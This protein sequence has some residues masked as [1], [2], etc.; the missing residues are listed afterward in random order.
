MPL[1]LYPPRPG[2]TPN[3]TIRGTYLGLR[4][5]K[6]AG[7]SRKATAQRELRRIEQ[8]IEAGRFDA[9]P[10]QTFADAVCSYL[11]GGGD[12]RFIEPLLDHFGLKPLTQIDQASVNAAAVTLY[13]DAS[14]ATR[15]WQVY[16]PVS[17]IL[18]HSGMEISFV[19][20][21]N[22]QGVP[23]TR[24]LKPAEAERLLEAGHEL[25]PEF[26]AF[27]TMLLYTG[28]RLSEALRIKKSEV[29]LD[30]SYM[31]CPVTKSA[32]PRAVHLPPPVLRAIASIPKA[33]RAR[34]RR[35]SGESEASW[36]ARARDESLR[37]FSFRKGKHLYQLLDRARTAAELGEDVTFHTL[38]H[39]Y[40]AWMR[41][42]GG[43][44]AR[45]L[46]ATGTW[47]DL[48]SVMRY[49]HVDTSEEARKADL[50]PD[51]LQGGKIV[52]RKTEDR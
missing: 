14:P 6:S 16:T 12:R 8:Q 42:Y 24:F 51:V 11:N 30:A 15:N 28:L 45:E 9:E 7:T 38:R 27:L 17:A 29:W 19:R 1:R 39:T 43:L 33:S 49:D 34:I 50:L 35:R 25:S 20:P 41:R 48:K 37:L 40:G 23:R 22:N 21:E 3:W 52:D 4:V 31:Y 47:R 10:E 5:D 18:K 2:K 36:T 26:G 32:T 44:G 13:P 46:V